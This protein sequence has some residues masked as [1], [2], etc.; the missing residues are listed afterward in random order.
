MQSEIQS[1]STYNHMDRS[2]QWF[3]K[4]FIMATKIMIVMNYHTGYFNV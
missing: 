4:L 1:N 2:Y 3:A